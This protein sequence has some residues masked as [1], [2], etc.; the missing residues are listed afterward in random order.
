MRLLA[1]GVQNCEV[2]EVFVIDYSEHLEGLNLQ[3]EPYAPEP[4]AN[5]Q[6]PEI[7]SW[8]KYLACYMTDGPE[9]EPLDPRKMSFEDRWILVSRIYGKEFCRK[10]FYHVMEWHVC[11][12][13]A[14][15]T[16]S[17][18]SREEKQ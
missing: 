11:A 2:L 15:K 16:G 4:K 1:G 9:Q 7:H 17:T 18:L 3:E 8:D 5:G 10:L 6:M 13:N 14:R 12:I